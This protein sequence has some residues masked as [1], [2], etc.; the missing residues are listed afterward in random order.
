[1][2][3][4]DTFYTTLN[5]LIIIAISFLGSLVP[6]AHF[7]HLVHGYMF[8]LF[9]S[10][11]GYYFNLGSVYFSDISSCS[12]VISF[13]YVLIKEDLSLGLAFLLYFAFVGFLI[14]FCTMFYLTNPGPLCS[15]IDSIYH[16]YAIGN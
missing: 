14:Y 3:A 8:L 1:M 10:F 16:F 7:I 15:D 4:A 2:S 12:P 6:T 11:A 5:I 13:D 9:L